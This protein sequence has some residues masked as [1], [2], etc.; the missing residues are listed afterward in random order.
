M[1]L[2]KKSSIFPDKMCRVMK[3]VDSYKDQAKAGEKY[4][5]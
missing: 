5:I 4:K 3:H 2:C 1:H